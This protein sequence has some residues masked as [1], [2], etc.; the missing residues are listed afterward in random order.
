MKNRAI[1][2]QCGAKL[3]SVGQIAVM[4]QCHMPFLVID[5]NRLAIIA[6]CTAGGAVAGM[7]DCHRSFRERMKDI[8]AEYFPDET[9]VLMGSE[10]AIIVDNNTAAFLAPM[11]KGIKAEINQAGNILRLLRHDTEYTAFFMDTHN[12]SRSCYNKLAREPIK[13]PC[14]QEMYH[15]SS[16]MSS[17]A[18]ITS[19]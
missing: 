6:V 16:A 14:L 18:K 11:L 10:H 13:L 17:H 19:K 1:H 8:A 15:Q 12:D 3:R 2:L 7:P 5:F 9:N 4:C